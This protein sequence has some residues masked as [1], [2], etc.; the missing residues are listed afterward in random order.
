MAHGDAV[1]RNKDPNRQEEV[2]LHPPPQKPQVLN[3]RAQS[4]Y[5]LNIQAL[6]MAVVNTA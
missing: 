6:H 2:T 1:F 4:L 5:T 3:A